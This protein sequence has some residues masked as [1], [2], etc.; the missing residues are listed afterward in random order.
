MAIILIKMSIKRTKPILKLANQNSM[1]RTDQN[2]G[3]LPNDVIW[4]IVPN[5]EIF[6]VV[7]VPAISHT[8][9]IFQ[10]IISCCTENNGNNIRGGW[11]N[12]ATLREKMFHPLKYCLNQFYLN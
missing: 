11:G 10:T 9:N 12:G 5:A 1:S 2:E 3:I 6:G 4:E 8:T 7:A